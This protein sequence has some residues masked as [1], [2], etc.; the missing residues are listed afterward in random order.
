M[1]LILLPNEYLG[2]GWEKSTEYSSDL[3][4]GVSYEDSWKKQSLNL[5]EPQCLSLYDGN[6]F[7]STYFTE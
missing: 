7:T 4:A 3:G 2:T 6:N 5:S 1:L